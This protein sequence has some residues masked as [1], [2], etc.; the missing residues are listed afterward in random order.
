MLC[1]KCGGIMVYEK[2]VNK[3]EYKSAISEIMSSGWWCSECSE[4]IFKGVELIAR[5]K[6]FLKLKEEIDGLEIITRKPI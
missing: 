4:V 5:E 3:I 6:A 1:F 2:R